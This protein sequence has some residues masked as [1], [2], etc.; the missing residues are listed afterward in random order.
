MNSFGRTTYG[1]MGP[2]NS[3]AATTYGGWEVDAAIQKVFE[4]FGQ[5]GYQ[6]DLSTIAS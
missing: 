5:M 1:G 6:Y 3:F 2:M 4:V